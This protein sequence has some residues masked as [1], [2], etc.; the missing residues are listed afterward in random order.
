MLT[1]D[2]IVACNAVSDYNDFA[3]GLKTRQVGVLLKR[4]FFYLPVWNRIFLK[5]HRT[6]LME[7]FFVILTHMLF[8]CLIILKKLN[9]YV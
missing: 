8:V 3:L 1:N 9:R 6:K 4:V 2:W 5:I 7:R